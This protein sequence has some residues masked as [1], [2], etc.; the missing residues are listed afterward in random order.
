[1][2]DSRGADAPITLILIHRAITRGLDQ[3]LNWTEA[4]AKEGY[5]DPATGR[6]LALFLRMLVGALHVHH[7]AEDEIAF[8]FLKERLPH[9]PLDVLATEHV[10]MA[11]ILHEIEATLE[12]LQGEEGEEAALRA[13]HPALVRLAEIWSGHIP[14]EETS[15]SLSELQSVAN[16]EEIGAWL[17]RMGQHRPPGSPPDPQLVPWLLHN[18]TPEDRASMAQFMPPQV[19]QELVP[20]PWK[21][22]WAPMGPFLID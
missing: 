19:T 10:Q 11:A 15:F 13:V 6:G 1:M 22:Q 5:P 21:E 17:A 16:P 8:P 18:L 4:Y 20:G 7:S 3:G 9:L 14:V 2:T 12:G